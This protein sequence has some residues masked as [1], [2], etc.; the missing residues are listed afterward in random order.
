M[1]NNYINTI[2]KRKLTI[3]KKRRDKLNKLILNKEKA[4]LNAGFNYSEEPKKLNKVLDEKQDIMQH[5][6]SIIGYKDVN[7]KQL[8][9]TERGH[10]L[11]T[12]QFSIYNKKGVTRNTIKNIS[13]KI[14]NI[15]KKSDI[16]GRIQITLLYKNGFKTNGFQDI[17]DDIELFSM[18]EYGKRVDKNKKEIPSLEQ[19]IFER[20]II[21]LQDY[22]MGNDNKLNDC[23]Y[24]CLYKAL[25]DDLP[26]KNATSLK[27][28]L[29]I[30]RFDMIDVNHIPKIEAKIKAK[31]IIS[32]DISYNSPYTSHT[33]IQ[34]K[35]VDFHCTLIKPKHDIDKLVYFKTRRP[36][37][38]N[39]LDHHVYDGKKEYFLTIEER[40]N[41]YDKKTDTILIVKSDESK[42][43]EEEYDEFIT[44]ADTLLKE[45]KGEINMYKT[46]SDVV[47]ALNLFY[48][49]NR[50][51][52]TDKISND[53]ADVI[54]KASKGALMFALDEFTGD[55]VYEYDIVSLY[56]SIMNSDMR[57]PIKH[58]EFK[59]VKTCDLP[60]F[61]Q[62]GLYN[63]VVTVKHGVHRG[64]Y[65]L[66]KN[67]WYTHYDMQRFKEL[68]FEVN[69]VE[70]N[71]N[72][73]LYYSRDKL[74][75]GKDLFGKYVNLL[76]GLKHRDVV[77]AKKVL[78]V[79]WGALC[80]THI[81][82][83]MVSNSEEIKISHKK[84]IKSLVPYNEE[85]S[86]VKLTDANSVFKYDY[87]RLKCFL[88]S[89][90]RC[91]MSRM[92]E[93]VVD[94]VIRFHTDG[95]L[96]G[97][98]LDGILPLGDSIGQL[99]YKGF[100]KDFVLTNINNYSGEFNKV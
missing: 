6:K 82:K 39:K 28:W 31:I 40:N 66:N 44:N 93:P 71:E 69:M 33:V 36:L 38:Y 27:V 7:I 55:T 32:G 54:L 46:G 85:F 52:Q 77:G 45:S 99:K 25:G 88:L 78:N 10:N 19:N 68:G 76:Y 4:I 23:L 86:I 67:N 72:N 48:K 34:L 2:E 100:Y 94:D 73:F 87:A 18:I 3:L 74:I 95:I 75:L 89:N 79:V 29:K 5:V 24:D 12:V 16:K 13:N 90:A 8:P 35:C 65:K 41:I 56:P 17:H 59:Y 9:F 80:Q 20:F 49:Y 60:E 51:I 58:G 37:I 96:I 81:N 21:T 62:Y 22:K 91:K 30:N 43:M 11:N 98:K 50:Y 70:D 83:K 26:F 61:F 97:Y 1:N 64:L 57:F 42:S 92:I 14:Q 63:A 53:E 84:E 15:Y 47:T